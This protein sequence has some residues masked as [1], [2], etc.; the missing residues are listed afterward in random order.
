MSDR[1]HATLRLPAR[2]DRLV[3]GVAKE[4]DRSKNQQIV[5]YIRL[6]LKADGA[7]PDFDPGDKDGGAS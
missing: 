6:G 7:L 2:L 3:E 4:R 1:A 5:R